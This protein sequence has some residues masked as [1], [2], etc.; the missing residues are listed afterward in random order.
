MTPTERRL[1]TRSFHSYDTATASEEGA[2]FWNLTV[3]G[4]EY[5]RQARMV[6]AGPLTVN[7]DDSAIAGPG[8]LAAYAGPGW[9]APWAY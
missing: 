6:G 4:Q 8:G 3:Y 2:G 1:R 7:S 5:I 9:G